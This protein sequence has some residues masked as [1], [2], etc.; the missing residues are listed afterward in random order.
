L[1]LG[2]CCRLL[3]GADAAPG[4]LLQFVSNG[5][6]LPVFHKAYWMG[7]YSNAD[8]FPRYMWYDKRFKNP[9]SGG[10]SNWGSGAQKQRFCVVGNYST[11]IRST[12]SLGWGDTN[13]SFTFPFI[14]RVQSGPSCTNHVRACSTC[15]LQQQVVIR[16]CLPARASW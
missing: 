2:G 5:T 7:L 15:L 13:C 11:Y 1:L 8:E 3:Q 14:C 6:L 9:G 16:G 12:S 10:F 4:P